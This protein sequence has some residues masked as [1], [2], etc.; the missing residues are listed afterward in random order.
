MPEQD[1]AERLRRLERTLAKLPMTRREIFLEHAV[2]GMSYRDIAG[3]TG[4]SVRQVEGHVAR[5]IYRLCREADRRPLRW[6]ER[7]LRR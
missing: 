5:A 3:R 6:W 4:L 2:D 1:H 7:L